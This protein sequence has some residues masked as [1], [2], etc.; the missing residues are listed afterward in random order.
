MNILCTFVL[1]MILYPF[2]KKGFKEFVWD[3][4]TLIVVPIIKGINK[5]IN[6]FKK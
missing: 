5:L 6:H 1:V 4:V 2:F 3:T